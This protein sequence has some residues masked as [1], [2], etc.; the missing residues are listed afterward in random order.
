MAA[1]ELYA[2]PAHWSQHAGAYAAL[3]V[4]GLV[5][6]FST[7]LSPL[8]LLLTVPIVGLGLLMLELVRRSDRL[9][10][11][12]DG[13][14]REF[15]FITSQ[16]TFVEYENIQDLEVTQSFLERLLGTGSIHVN[17][18][19]SA[20]KEIVFRSVQRFAEIEAVIRDRMGPRQVDTAEA[21]RVP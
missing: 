1:E 13:I 4:V 10:L 17:T 21:V 9:V 16:R 2:T 14:A 19:G 8:F 7:V 3:A 6:V 5:G 18:A 20:H 15:K 11:Y 12:A